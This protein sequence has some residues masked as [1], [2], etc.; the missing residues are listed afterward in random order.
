MKQN[1]F[2]FEIKILLECKTEMRNI[3]CEHGQP[4][5]QARS[6]FCMCDSGVAC[7]QSQ[8]SLLVNEF[9]VRSVLHGQMSLT[10]VNHVFHEAMNGYKNLKIHL[11]IY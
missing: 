3:Q 7:C 10:A 1:K 6:W 2:V 4:M 5:D 8:V 11:K 9:D